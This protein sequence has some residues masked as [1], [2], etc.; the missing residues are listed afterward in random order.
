M[1]LELHGWLIDESIENFVPIETTF[2]DKEEDEILLPDFG[3]YAT[4]ETSLGLQI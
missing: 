3:F 4:G 2:T 1:L